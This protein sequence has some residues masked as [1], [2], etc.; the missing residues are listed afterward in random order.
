MRPLG[1]RRQGEPARVQP[2]RRA[3]RHVAE[4]DVVSTLL[5]GDPR[6]P[7]RCGISFTELS[8]LLKGDSISLVVVHLEEV[9]LRVLVNWRVV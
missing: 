4:R 8:I 5:K 9:S 6:S 7:T 3:E 1:L 2:R